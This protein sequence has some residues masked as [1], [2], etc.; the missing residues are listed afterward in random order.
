MSE[1]NPLT[2][3][4]LIKVLKEVKKQS[5]DLPVMFYLGVENGV[6][7]CKEPKDIVIMED[8]DREKSHVLRRFALIK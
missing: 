3:S 2:I 1:Q 5:G 8:R 6:N 7:Q 4:Q